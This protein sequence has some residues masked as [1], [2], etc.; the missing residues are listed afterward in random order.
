MKEGRFDASCCV[1]ESRFIYVFGGKAGMGFPLSSIERYDTLEDS[2]A[3]LAIN[4]PKS[5][6]K[7]KIVKVNEGTILIFGGLNS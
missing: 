1:M 4:L 5:L 7:T 2:W 3:L 6:S